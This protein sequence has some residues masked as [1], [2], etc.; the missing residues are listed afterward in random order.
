MGK[1]YI[2]EMK[3]GERLYKTKLNALNEPVI[4]EITCEPYIEPD[5]KQVKESAYLE[6]LNDGQSIIMES[7]QNNA[8]NN[9]Y[10]KCLEDMAQIRK[11]AYGNGYEAAKYEC[12]DCPKQAYTDAL[13]METYQQGLND[14]W[15][16]MQKAIKMY[17]EI[18]N[19]VYLRVFYDV[20]TD[21]GESVLQALFK[22]TPQHVIDSIRKYEENKEKHTWICSEVNEPSFDTTLICSECGY[23][24]K[25]RI[26]DTPALNFCPKCGDNKNPGREEKNEDP[27]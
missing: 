19:E 8:F 13:K 16:A 20:N 23:A 4:R 2:V 25:M 21:W 17:C 9:G 22:N 10:K 12:K 18:D 27:A 26:G 15:E 7:T 14:L 5:L 11:E 1:K 6:G 24:M 3:E